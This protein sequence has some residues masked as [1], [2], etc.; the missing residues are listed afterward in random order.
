MTTKTPHHVIGGFVHGGSSPTA[1]VPRDRF[2]R[3]HHRRD[4][5]RHGRYRDGFGETEENEWTDARYGMSGTK[6]KNERTNHRARK[7]LELRNSHSCVCV[8]FNLPSSLVYRRPSP[9]CSFRRRCRGSSITIV[10][11]RVVGFIF[12]N[13]I[14]R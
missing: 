8:V 12:I 14:T 11:Y 1:E 2:R 4:E 3:Q 13:W 6:K 7:T 10:S 5:C 9:V